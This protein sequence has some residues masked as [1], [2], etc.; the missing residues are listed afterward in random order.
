MKKEE[1]EK[2]IREIVPLLGKLDLYSLDLVK[3][4][5]DALAARENI[6]KISEKKG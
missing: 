2:V 6:E 1:R 4:S 3:S 5:V